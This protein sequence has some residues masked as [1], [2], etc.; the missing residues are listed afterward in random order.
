MQLEGWGKKGSGK[1]GENT[2]STKGGKD[3][4]DGKFAGKNPWLVGRKSWS[5]G[6]SAWSSWGKKGKGSEKSE[7]DDSH[8]ECWH[9]GKAGH[10]VSACPT[11]GA[12]G[13]GSESASIGSSPSFIGVTENRSPTIK[14]V[15]LFQPKSE[16]EDLP[17]DKGG[18]VQ[19]MLIDPGASLHIGPADLLHRRCGKVP[20]RCL[21]TVAGESMAYD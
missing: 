10:Y 13:K 19:H 5:A 16:D 17:E 8:M 2:D 3:G 6:G 14:D 18:A 12:S 7:K 1:K 21:P 9:C 4:K 11:K 15:R 20:G